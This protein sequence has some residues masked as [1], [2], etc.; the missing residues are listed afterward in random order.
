MAPKNEQIDTP[1]RHVATR[2]NLRPAKMHR[3][4]GGTMTPSTATR[5][6]VL[7]LA[8]SSPATE[9]ITRLDVWE[10]GSAAVRG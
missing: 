7:Y 5:A 2:G 4:H 1:Y 3:E 6:G 10:M 8:V 9:S